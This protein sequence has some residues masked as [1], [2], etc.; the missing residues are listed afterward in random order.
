MA[1]C[2]ILN[3]SSHEV[4]ALLSSKIAAKYSG[5]DLEAM[6]IIA[7]AAKSHSLEDFQKS[8]DKFESVLRSDY[9]IS[10]HLDILYDKMLES[11]LLKII[12]PYR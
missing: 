5:I 3:E 12:N 6:S 11:N 1:L 10:H 7:K 9:L 4:P 8:V 2:K